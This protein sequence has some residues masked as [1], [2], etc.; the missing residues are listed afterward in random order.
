MDNA[1][2]IAVEK[3]ENA[4][5]IAVEKDENADAIAVENGGNDDENAGGG[6]NAGQMAIIRYFDRAIG[7]YPAPLATQAETVQKL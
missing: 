6:G 5:G 3:D 4:D 7:I 2:G 1:D